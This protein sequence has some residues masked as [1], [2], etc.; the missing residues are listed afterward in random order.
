MNPKLTLEIRIA[1]SQHPVGPIRLEDD[2]FSEPVFVVRLADIP[3]LQSLV[4]E[5]IRERLEEAD[6]DI[7]AGNV[8]SWDA[9]DIKRRGRRRLQD[10]EQDD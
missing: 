9:A 2:E 10:R 4:D 3:N 1:L 6:G 7:A 5:R 8:A